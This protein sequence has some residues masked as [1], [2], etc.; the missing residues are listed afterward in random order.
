MC[1]SPGTQ[2]C[3]DSNQKPEETS[4][5]SML[6]SDG[7]SVHNLSFFVESQTQLAAFVFHF[8]LVHQPDRSGGRGANPNQSPSTGY[9]VWRTERFRVLTS[10][11]GVGCRVQSHR[12][13]DLRNSIVRL[14]RMCQGPAEEPWDTSGKALSLDRGP[15]KRVIHP[16]S[17]TWSVARRHPGAIYRPGDV[18]ARPSDQAGESPSSSWSEGA[19]QA[20]YGFGSEWE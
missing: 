13:G 7:F 1:H 3:G 5:H 16:S 14:G 11:V 19:G 10:P 20:V 8:D 12:P 4:T 15:V 18:R 17:W 2:K 6:V 9:G